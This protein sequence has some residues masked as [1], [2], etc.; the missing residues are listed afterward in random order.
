MAELVKTYTA[1]NQ[2]ALQDRKLTGVV[3][4]YYLLRHLHPV[5]WIKEKKE[6]YRIS[7]EYMGIHKQRTDQIISQGEGVYWDWKGPS[8]CF[9]SIKRVIDN[10]EVE[11]LLP[12]H[13]FETH[14]KFRS[15]LYK[16]LDTKPD[17]STRKISR[18]KKSELLGISKTTQI[19]Y[20]K[21]TGIKTKPTFTYSKINEHTYSHLILR[22]G[23]IL[24][25]R[26]QW[27]YDIDR[28]GEVELVSQSVNEYSTDLIARKAP[29]RFRKS[30]YRDGKQNCKRL[31]YDNQKACI[32]S[33]SRD[34]S[35]AFML[36]RHRFG[37]SKASVYEQ[38]S[39]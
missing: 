38:V 13:L 11:V 15:G 30:L 19:K 33:V 1:I 9:R 27:L 16:T 6:V 3:R 31:F 37:N 29:K 14:G 36:T 17:G 5:G 21:L 25:Q 26:G 34:R 24:S 20:E 18:H 4:L 35:T 23:E 32:K 7:L 12:I 22:D 28:D 2:M 10:A 39:F 8:L